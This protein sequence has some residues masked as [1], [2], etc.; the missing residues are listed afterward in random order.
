MEA[1]VE[2]L[3]PA[4]LHHVASQKNLS[5]EHPRSTLAPCLVKV[6][7][8]CTSLAMRVL[9][10]AKTDIPCQARRSVP[11]PTR[12]QQALQQMLLLL[13]SGPELLRFANPRTVVR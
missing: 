7:L 9:S 1:G 10:N 12:S 2:Q 3:L 6:A 11:V 4:H 13:P 5:G 8:G